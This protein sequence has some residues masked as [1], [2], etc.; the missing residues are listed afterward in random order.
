MN[1]YGNALRC[2]FELIQLETGLEGIFLLRNYYTY[3]CIA[4]HSWFKILWEC[5]DYYKVRLELS[6]LFVPMVREHEKVVTE[7]VIRLIP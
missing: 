3:E 4:T 1:E 6:D 7:E 5:L 2:I